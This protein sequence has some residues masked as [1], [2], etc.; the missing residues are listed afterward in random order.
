[1][2]ETHYK[3]ER[4]DLTPQIPKQQ[5]QQHEVQRAD[6]HPSGSLQSVQVLL[7]SLFPDHLSQSVL[8]TTQSW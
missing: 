7:Q 8:P 4:Q 1:M 2:I 3:H 5:D 6:L